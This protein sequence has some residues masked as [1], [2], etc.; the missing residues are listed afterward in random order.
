MGMA[1]RKWAES[2]AEIGLTEEDRKLVAAWLP[3][4]DR[5]VPAVAR[6]YYDHL[7]T[8]EVGALLAPDR[9]ERLL[10]ARI[11]HWRMLLGGDFDAVSNDYLERFGRRLFEAGFPMRIFVVATG[12][13][14][15]E[16]G[17]FVACCPEIPEP[18]RTD[19]HIALTR[20]AFLDLL[21]AHAACEVTYLD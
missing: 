10:E 18:V 8:T 3:V 1:T 6:R 15:S 12:W 4:L 20:F 2:V 5:E 9:I 14:C 21:L 13:F 16:F 17:R 19:L 11:A 7:K